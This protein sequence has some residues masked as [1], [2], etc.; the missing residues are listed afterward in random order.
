MRTSRFCFRNAAVP[1]AAVLVIVL[2]SF[3]HQYLLSAGLQKHTVATLFDNAGQQATS[4][5]SH[6]ENQYADLDVVADLISEYDSSEEAARVLKSL[7][8]RLIARCGILHIGVV[9]A[10]GNVTLNNGKTTFIADRGYFQSSMQGERAIERVY[11][12]RLT[13]D[14]LFILSVPIWRDGQVQGV[15][16]GSFSADTFPTLLGKGVYNGSSFSVLCDGSGNLLASDAEITLPENVETIF[17]LFPDVTSLSGDATGSLAQALA[18]GNA[19][20]SFSATLADVPQYVTC[21]PLGVSNWYIVNAVSESAAGNALHYIHTATLWMV[22]FTIC[23]GVSMMVYIDLHEK[24]IIT[25]LEEEKELLRSSEESYTL[26]GMLSSEVIFSGDF[27]TGKLTFN[28]NFSKVFGREPDQLTMNLL[29]TVPAYIYADD[30]D[31]YLSIA[32]ILREGSDSGSVELR[33]CNAADVP[34]WQRVDFLLVRD[35]LNRPVRMVGK[36][37]NIDRQKQALAELQKQAQSDPLTSLMNRVT[38]REQVEAFLNG[39]GHNGLHA[40]FM[41]DLDNFKRTNDTMGHRVGDRILTSFAD[42]LQRLFRTSD[43]LC[44]MGG[45]EFALFLKDISSYDRIAQKAQE[46]CSCMAAFNETLDLHITAS[47]GIA[48]YRRD[49]SNFDELYERADQALYRAKNGGKNRFVI[50]GDEDGVS[51]L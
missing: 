6:F 50:Y 39:V 10:D 25:R 30:K 9:D 32:R 43:Y 14:S 16:F 27:S 7:M 22:L 34:I 47:V 49:G 19:S 41:I 13:H 18:A 51:L 46:I 17:E 12:A 35:S 8:E 24:K 45:D 33:I 31:V 37:T 4:I 23:I 21:V 29:D 5:H 26:V 38:M 36:L 40:F 28:R 42:Q 11:P 1:I 3:F 2:A 44:R 20:F 15:L 48:V